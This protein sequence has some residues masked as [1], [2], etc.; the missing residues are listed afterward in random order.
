[1]TVDGLDERIVVGVEQVEAQAIALEPF[2]ADLSAGILP[3]PDALARARHDIVNMVAALGALRKV[4]AR[5]AAQRGTAHRQ[6]RPVSP[7]TRE[8]RKPTRR[9]AGGGKLG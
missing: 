4:M 9:Q 7:E 6:R 1:M 2:I 3:D 8:E 5:E